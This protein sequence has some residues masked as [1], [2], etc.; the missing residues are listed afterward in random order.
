MI[1]TYELKI[2]IDTGHSV[3]LYPRKLK[4]CIDGFKLRKV[5][6]FTAQWLKG[7]QVKG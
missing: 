6:K 7:Y 5:S 1:S 3:H 2:L 4:V